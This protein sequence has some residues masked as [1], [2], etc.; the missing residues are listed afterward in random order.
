MIRPAT[1]LAWPRRDD[2]TPMVVLFRSLHEHLLNAI[3]G[4]RAQDAYEYARLL[5]YLGPR[6]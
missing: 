5:A 2:L 4:G 6:L 3:Q 1:A